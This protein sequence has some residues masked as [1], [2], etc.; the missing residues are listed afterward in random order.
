MNQPDFFGPRSL[1]SRATVYSMETVETKKLPLHVRVLQNELDERKRRNPRYSMRALARLLSIDPSALSRALAG[2][3]DLSLETCRL[4]LEKLNLPMTQARLFIASVSED[5]RNRANAILT[6]ALEPRYIDQTDGDPRFEQILDSEAQVPLAAR[7]VYAF[8][9]D[10]VS[11]MDLDGHFLYANETIARSLKAIPCDL[12]G[13]DWPATTFDVHTPALLRKQQDEMVASEKETTFEFA[14]GHQE[15]ARILRRTIIPVWGSD[16]KMN[17][18]ISTIRDVTWDRFLFNTCVDVH[19]SLETKKVLEKA[20][21]LPT[22][23]LAD[24]CAILMTNPPHDLEASH[25]SAG[26]GSYADVVRPFVSK[27]NAATSPRI[28]TLTSEQSRLLTYERK[29]PTH[30]MITPLDVDSEISGL[31]IFLGERRFHDFDLH[32]AKDYVHGV[33]SALRNAKLYEKFA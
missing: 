1:I 24:G 2:K 30:S 13:E 9:K 21:K 14:V 8:E 22:P 32:I 4:I 27:L 19:S 7:D 12:I 28:E 20:V 23:L 18:F 5:K 15:N 11:V 17:A 25:R 33:A 29:T 3:Q 26:A 10:F 6:R 31:V 16:G